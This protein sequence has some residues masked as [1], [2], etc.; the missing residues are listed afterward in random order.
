MLFVALN[1]N[2][3]AVYERVGLQSPPTN[4]HG[5]LVVAVHRCVRVG[6]STPAHSYIPYA[7]ATSVP[8]LTSCVFR[9]V[10]C[11]E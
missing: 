6:G 3:V 9:V 10:A 8:N 1:E 11:L 7:Y 2:V 4:T 5:L